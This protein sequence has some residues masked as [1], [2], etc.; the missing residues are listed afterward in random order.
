M[1]G[2]MY[3]LGPRYEWKEEIAYLNK[4]SVEYMMGSGL[5][6]APKCGR[7]YTGELSTGKIIQ[8]VGFCGNRISGKKTISNGSRVKISYYKEHFLMRPGTKWF[9]GYVEP[10]E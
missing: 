9:L 4:V 3:V 5:R 6:G 2:M 7:V 8:W 1:L 10:L